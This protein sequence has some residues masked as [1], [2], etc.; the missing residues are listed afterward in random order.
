VT[1]RLVVLFGEE[2]IPMEPTPPTEPQRRD[3]LKGAA[4]VGIGGLLALPPGVAALQVVLD[5]LQRGGESSLIAVTL[6]DGLPADGLPRRFTLVCDRVDAWNR[7]AG[8]PIGAI[9]LRRTG[10]RAVQA[11]NVVCPHLGC[12]VEALPDGAFLCPCHNSRFDA[13]GRIDR[14]GGGAVPSPRDL[15]ALET[16]LEETPEGTVVRVRFQNFRAGIPEKIPDS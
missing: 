16:A 9:F 6:L 4:T 14:S 11:F 10:P 1:S 13:Q 15:D 2:R 5:P 8:V 7:C 3:F 12:S